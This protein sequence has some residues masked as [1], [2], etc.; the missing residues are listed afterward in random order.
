MQT[1]IYNTKSDILFVNNIIDKLNNGAVGIFPTDTVY[2]IG[3][4]ALD[5]KALEKL[6][7]IKQRSLNKPINILVSSIEMAKKYIENIN[8]IEK[9]LMNCFWPGGLTIIFQKSHIIPNLLTAG[10]DTVGI[11]MPNNKV[12]LDIIDKFG[13]PLAM[14][15][16]NISNKPPDNN[17]NS[18]MLDFSSKVDFIIN[19]GELHNKIPST[20]VKVEDNKINILREGSICRSDICKYWEV[21]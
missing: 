19:D 9:E 10:F 17:L 18:L 20:I 13:F 1:V 3:C 12:C 5:C 2:G 6:Y 7:N 15:S 4:N 14:S 16:A 11:R 8:T 21:I